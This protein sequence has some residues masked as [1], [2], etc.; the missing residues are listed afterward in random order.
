MDEIKWLEEW[1]HCTVKEGRFEGG[2]DLSKLPEIIKVFR[3]WAE[4]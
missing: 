4:S 2:G 1:I 3:N